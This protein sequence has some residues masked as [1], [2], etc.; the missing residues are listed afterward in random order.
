MTAAAHEV[1]SSIRFNLL[2]RYSG[3]SEPLEIFRRT[4]PAAM[5]LLSKGYQNAHSAP[6]DNP[7]VDLR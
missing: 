2:L 7:E 6:L 1:Y 4:F 3:S 5:L